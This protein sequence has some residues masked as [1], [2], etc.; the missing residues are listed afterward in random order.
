MVSTM[1][2]IGGVIGMEVAAGLNDGAGVG[3]FDGAS[4][5]DGTKLGGAEIDGF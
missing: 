3:T 2:T 4:E 1:F 5:K